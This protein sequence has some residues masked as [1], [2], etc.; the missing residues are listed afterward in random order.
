MIMTIDGS[1]ANGSMHSS[2]ELSS[3]PETM[4]ASVL[5]GPGKVVIQERPVPSPGPGE[6]LIQ[7]GSVGICGSDVHYYQHGRIA[8]YV[9]R[10]P[11]ILG[12]EAGGRIVAVGT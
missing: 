7:I 10:E 5:L 8:E 11:L 6:V 9:V 3:V 12:H 4:R 1:P 2:N